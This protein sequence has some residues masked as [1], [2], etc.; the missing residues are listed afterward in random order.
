MHEKTGGNG[1]VALLKTNTY[2]PGAEWSSQGKLVMHLAFWDASFPLTV[3]LG[4]FLNL[5]IIF[6]WKLMLKSKGTTV[7]W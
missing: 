2:Q 1:A 5:F 6:L 7:A 4:H 3:L